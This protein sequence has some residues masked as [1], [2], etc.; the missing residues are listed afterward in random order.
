MVTE[1]IVGN[2]RRWVWEVSRRLLTSAMRGGLPRAGGPGIQARGDCEATMDDLGYGMTYESIGA[3]RRRD[4]QDGGPMVRWNRLAAE[5]AAGHQRPVVRAFRGSTAHPAAEAWQGD[6]FARPGDRL[7]AIGTATFGPR[8]RSVVVLP[9]RSLDRWHEPPAETRSYEER[10]LSS[11]FEL[12]DP[13]LELTYVTSLPV[14]QRTIDYYISLLPPTVRLS[15]RKRLRLVSLGDS[16]RRPLS[17][18]L[19]ARPDVL[20]Q[21]RGTLA[22]PRAAYLMPY[23]STA[24]ERDIALALDIP[25]YGA[26]P[27]HGWLGTKSGGRALFAHTGVPHPLGAANIRSVAQAI[28]AICALRAARS[29]LAELVIKLDNGVSGEGNALLDLSGM[30]APGSCGERELIHQRLARLVPEVDGV[31]SGT[32]LRKLAAQGGVVEERITARE[33]RSPSV[34]LWITPTRAVE[35]LSTHEQ[36]LNGRNGQQFAGCRFP[37]DPAYA[38]VVSVL[39]R[40]LAEQLADT[41]V[42]G[43]LGV[44]FLVARDDHDGWQ[45]FALELNLRMSGTSHPYQTLALLTRGSYDPQTACF[46]T[47]RGQARHYVATDHLET[48]QL[49]ALGHAGLLSRAAR[50]DLRFDRKQGR[51]VVFHMLSS[52]EPLATVGVTA[53]AD[54]P[55]QA[56]NLYAHARTVLTDSGDK[57]PLKQ[58]SPIR[59]ALD[60]TG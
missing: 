39:A 2:V 60:T 44:D 36:I 45:P 8:R 52:I 40:R 21:I 20:E 17:E 7:A 34:Q 35:V 33:L 37:A 54:S 19:L 58:R 24:V 13:G 48:P 26:D 23:N 30:A 3:G 49:R 11:L 53:I 56:D 42:I 25:L 51:G 4:A 14:A 32:F 55:E 29:E 28:D 43:P 31:S 5:R 27:D 1:M 47:G 18:K 22:G 15:A 16:G 41:G 46:T 38:P 50:P 12:Q 59:P 6:R 57:Q 10:L 9:S